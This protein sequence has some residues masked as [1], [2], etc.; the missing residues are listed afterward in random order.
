MPIA[1]TGFLVS[2]LLGGPVRSAMR[3]SGMLDTPN[4]RSS[5]VNPTPRGGGLACL[6]G[7]WAA[8]A[9]SALTGREVP[10]GLMIGATALALVGLADDR[11]SIP[12]PVRLGAQLAVGPLLGWAAGGGWLVLLGAVLTPPVVN[13]VNFM[14]GIDGISGLTM[15]V[16]GG[17][18]W[19]VGAQHDVVPLT[20]TGAVVVGCALGFLPWNLPVARMFLGDVGSYLF[21]GLVVAGILLA[22]AHQAPVLPLLAPL[23]L[24]AVDTAT[25]LVRRA[26]RGESLL[27][28][29]REHIYQRLVVGQQRPHRVVA[30]GAA[31]LAAVATLAWLFAGAWV[32]VVVTVGA[33]ALYC[34][35]PRLL[36]PVDRASLPRRGAS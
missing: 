15:A 31:A 14:D 25:T 35:S 22:W 8:C 17:A 2:F 12:A 28:A 27:D 9:V 6:L 24:Y 19:V 20:V 33:A 34:A 5:H 1:V 23:T 13:M 18:A 26:A 29:H 4:H 11:L 30:T 16:W 32:A 21:G 36:V 10:W 3:R 7:I